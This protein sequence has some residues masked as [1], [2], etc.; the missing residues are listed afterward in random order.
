VA[1]NPL[2]KEQAGLR[3][4]ALMGFVAG[5]R[6]Q[7]PLASLARAVGH[8]E[9]AAPSGPLGAPLR[10]ERGRQILLVAAVGEAIVDKTPLALSRLKRS[11]LLGRLGS[12]AISAATLAQTQGI[13]VGSA[14][15]R[16]AA[17]AGIGS[18]IG[19][20]FRTVIGK[21]TGLPDLVVA[22]AEDAI[23]IGLARSAIRPEAIAELAAEQA[24]SAAPPGPPAVAPPD[25]G[26][27][28]TEGPTVPPPSA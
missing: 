7:I 16:G 13:P 9:I 1:S 17:G 23:A 8:G 20:L 4:A 12:G 11:A 28:G 19:Y 5:L 18:V 21:A 3:R 24:E 6:S 15:I 25:D 26:E 2:T 27:P 10:S 14:A 22:L